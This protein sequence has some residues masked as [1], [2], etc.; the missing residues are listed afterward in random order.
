MSD[1]AITKILAIQAKAK[2]DK[3]AIDAK[4]KAAIAELKEEAREAITKKRADAKSLLS[5]VEKEYAEI[6]GRKTKKPKKKSTTPKRPPLTPEQLEA[7]PKKV[8]K[9]IR[10][11]KEP[12]SMGAII[13]AV[14]ASDNAIRKVIKANPDLIVQTGDKSTARYA[15]VKGK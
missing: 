15:I 13:K 2:E 14:D 12:I 4:A 8:I 3:A 9:A 5:T 10:D 7:L 1:T 11:S 6:F